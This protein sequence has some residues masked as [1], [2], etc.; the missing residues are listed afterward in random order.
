MTSEKLLNYDPASEANTVNLQDQHLQHMTSHT[1]LRTGNY[2]QALLSNV[3]ALKSALE[4]AG[5][6]CLPILLPWVTTPKDAE[7][8]LGMVA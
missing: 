6:N 7:R 4:L 3:V 5:P 8:W 2:H 1:Y